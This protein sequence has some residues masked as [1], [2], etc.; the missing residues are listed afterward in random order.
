MLRN[1]LKKL[2]WK[3]SEQIKTK[4][5]KKQSTPKESVKKFSS[6]IAPNRFLKFYHQ[7]K[8]RLNVERRGSYKDRKAHGICVRC[9]KKS[10]PYI[11]FCEYHQ[12]KQ[13]SYNLKAR[14]AQ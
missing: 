14:M 9:Q 5:L 1:L 10:L 2:V 6:S 4:P 3:K 8:S 7:N 12:R 13:K 11:V